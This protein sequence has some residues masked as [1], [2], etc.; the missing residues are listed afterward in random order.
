[1]SGARSVIIQGAPLTPE[2]PSVTVPQLIRARARELTAKTAIIDAAS[3]R[4]YTYG[5]FDHL[6]GRFA[7]GLAALG[8]GSGDRLLLFMPNQ[9]EWLIA[10][11][12]AMSAGGMVSGANS[13]YS[14]AELARQMRDAAARFVMTVPAYLPAVRSAAQ[15]LGDITIIL[16]GE[17]PGTVSLASMLACTDSEPAS[18]ADADALAALP[19]SSGT[20]GLSKGV[21]LTHRNIVSNIIQCRQARATPE[22]AVWLAFLPMFHIYGFATSM[23]YLNLGGTMVTLPRFEPQPFLKAVQDYRVTNLSVVPPVLQFLAM[24][25]LVDSFD[26]SSLVHVGSGAAPLGVELERRAAVRLKCEVN[27][28]FGMTESSCVIAATWVGRSRMGSC[29]ELMPGTQARVVDPITQADLDRGD[30]GE[31]WFRGPQAFQGYLNN[32]TTTAATITPDGW[33]RTGDIGYFDSDGYLFIT[34][35]LKELIKVKGF[36]VAPAELEALLLTHPSVVDS[37]VIGRAHERAGEV[38][39]AYVVVRGTIQPEELKDWVAERVID[40]KHLGEVIFC[41]TIPKSPTGKIL[42]RVLRDE[43]AK[44]VLS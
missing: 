15:E 14:A 24:H 11:V 35:R 18:A 22:S 29:G 5:E 30:C 28:G 12:G 6:V 20:S 17:A 21:M 8:F 16:L 40:Y 34:D 41:E 44:R 13:T 27:Q 9:P 2:V 23:Y 26:L 39:V 32:P 43:D 4:S 3:G 7:A 38:P 42:R 37:A 36:Q 19:Y 33:V 31:I 1:M 25:P 10:A